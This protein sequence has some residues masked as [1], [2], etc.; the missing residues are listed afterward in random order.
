MGNR[1][2]CPCGKVGTF[3]MP[4]TI[5]VPGTGLGIWCKNCK[6]E[7]AIDVVNIKCEK[8]LLKQP[9]YCLEGEEK[10]RWCFDCKEENSIDNKHIK[11]PCPLK[12]RPNFNLPGEKVAIWC[13]Q[14]PNKP[15]NAINVLV[16]LCKCG[17]YASYGPKGTKKKIFCAKCAPKDF[18][19][20]A[21]RR[22]C[23]VCNKRRCNFNIPSETR[24]IWC[25]ECR[26]P[27][28]IDVFHKKCQ[29]GKHQASFCDKDTSIRKY[30]T[31]CKP[32]DAESTGK[33]CQCGKV[34]VFGFPEKRAMYCKTCRIP[35]TVDLN[36]KKCL[37]EFC[38]TRPNPK[39]ECKGYCMRC[40][41]HLYPDVEI[42][43]NYKVKERHVID[44][45]LLQLKKYLENKYELSNDQIFRDKQI[46]G[47][48]SKRRPDI[49]FDIGSHWICG[50][51]DED[52]HKD[53]DT[54]CE[55]KRTM[56]LYTDMGNRPMILIRFNCD[57]YIKKDGTI[58]KSLFRICKRTGMSI[59]AD[60]NKFNE[61]IDTFAKMVSEYIIGQPPEKA[62][63][64][65]YLFYE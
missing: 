47:S 19:C 37:T 2:R 8:C 6:K 12:L 7:G 13:A 42:S 9:T 54:T 17:T 51:N 50:E 41:I 57:K 61:R 49:M 38:E 23:I 55:N 15:E 39:K 53:Y 44:A 48:C 33:K 46:P 5:T 43:R 1:K 36:H 30:C 59:I 35:G 62:I 40:F 56:E 20:T 27:H 32:K 25:A 45:L 28:T 16:K 52:C 29:C 31:S 63:T 14:C 26:P 21:S 3:N 10:A 64:T 60:K 24:G 11:C 34:P 4:D 22:L 18:E 58:E 65:E